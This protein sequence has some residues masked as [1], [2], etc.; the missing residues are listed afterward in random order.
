[1]KVVELYLTLLFVLG[2]IKEMVK[3]VTVFVHEE[4]NSQIYESCKNVQYPEVRKQTNKLIIKQT[5]K[6]MN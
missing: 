5:D 6:P 1:M 3:E 2:K 4:F